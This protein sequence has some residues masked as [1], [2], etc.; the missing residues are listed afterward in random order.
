MKMSDFKIT[1]EQKAYL[2]SLVCQRIS[3]DKANRDVIDTFSNYENPGLPDALKNGWG[4]DE[5]DELAF[6][7]IKDPADQ[8]PLLFFSL[9]AGILHIPFI[10]KK[11]AEACREAE[12]LYNAAR[13][14]RAPKWALKEIERLKVDGV[15]PEEIKEYLKRDYE[16]K[17]AKLAL[18]MVEMGKNAPKILQ[19]EETHPGV[20]LVHLCI[21]EPAR[22][23]WVEMGMDSKPMG[24]TLFWYFV[25]PK[26]QEIRRLI[27][28]EYIYLFAAD[29][30]ETA[31]LIKHYQKLGF[32][33]R[34]DIGVDKPAYDFGCIFMCQKLTALRNRRI[35]FL[36]T[37][38]EPGKK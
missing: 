2:D 23:K 30:S 16:N 10:Y 8:E 20:E 29:N 1:K 7:I 36:N 18:F 28:C 11:V 21:H 13:N 14:R 22:E 12:A 3:D 19:V 6:Y 35:E 17:R 24:Q 4:K 34:L 9:Q 5:R 33:V 32:E 15:L 27:C 37:Y 25:A 38:N 31:R 26:V